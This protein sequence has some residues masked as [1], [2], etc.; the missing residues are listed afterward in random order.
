MQPMEKPRA[1]WFFMKKISTAPGIMPSALAVESKAAS[2][3]R[4]A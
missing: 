1:M 4:Q 3:G 2:A